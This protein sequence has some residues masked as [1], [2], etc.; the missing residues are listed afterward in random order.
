[1]TDNI[2]FNIVLKCSICDKNTDDFYQASFIEDGRKKKGHH[3]LVCKDCH[4]RAGTIYMIYKPNNKSFD[5]KCVY[6]IGSTTDLQHTIFQHR[7]DILKFNK[8]DTSHQAYLLHYL[9]HNLNQTICSFYNNPHNISPNE[10]KWEV[11]G[12]AT[13][14]IELDYLENHFI[15]LYKPILSQLPSSG[16]A[17]KFKATIKDVDILINEYEKGFKN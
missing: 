2:S 5:N 16:V 13:S 6:Y 4:Y 9:L 3:S 1:M 12:N 7:R 10:W 11:L 14:K 15:N 8:Y 17:N